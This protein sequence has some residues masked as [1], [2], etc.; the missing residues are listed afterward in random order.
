MTDLKYNSVEEFG[1]ALIRAG[2]LDPIYEMLVQSPITEAQL[3]KWLV[4]YWCFYH[5]GVASWI[6]EQNDFWK[7][8]LHA[9][10]TNAPRGAE[11]RHFRGDSPRES[12]QKIRQW[13]PEPEWLIEMLTEAGDAPLITFRQIRERVKSLPHF[14]DWIAFKVA[15][16]L[17]RVLNFQVDFTDCDLYMY[18]APTQ[19]AAFVFADEDIAPKIAALGMD[20]QVKRGWDWQTGRKLEDKVKATV[21]Y[22][23]YQFR[24]DKAPPKFD[25]TINVQE[26]ETI[27]CK[28]KS[29]RNGQ[30]PIGKDRKEIIHGLSNWGK[31]AGEL[32]QA[33]EI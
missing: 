22:L 12:I 17:E 26:V 16:M 18:E 1:R 11:R 28:Y 23:L 31:L 8:V 32:Q 27:L 19:G 3:K 24:E 33:L 13:Y 25:R 15:D 21:L 20:K 29:H 5:A 7:A 10:D 30:Y 14:G 2:D 6:T 9:F 4:A